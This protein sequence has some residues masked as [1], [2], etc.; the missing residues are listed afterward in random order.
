MLHL[1][2]SLAYS[3]LVYSLISALWM[4]L[5]RQCL[6]T[7]DCALCLHFWSVFLTIW[8]WSPW[9]A[10]TAAVSSLQSYHC[11]FVRFLRSQGC[12]EFSVLFFFSAPMCTSEKAVVQMRVPGVRVLLLTGRKLRHSVLFRAILASWSQCTKFQEWKAA[13]DWK[14]H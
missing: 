1:E 7:Q 6:M 8:G 10:L 9:C 3:N 13:V 5:F 12:H 2:D 4:F 11:W 14:M